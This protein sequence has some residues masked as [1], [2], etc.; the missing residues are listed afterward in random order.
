MLLG[1]RSPLRLGLPL[2]PPHQEAEG[3]GQ[4]R[5]HGA[6]HALRHL[7]QHG[8]HRH[9][10]GQLHGRGPRAHQDHHGPGDKGP[11][12]RLLNT[13]S[14]LLFNS[15][16]S[17]L[18]SCAFYLL[19]SMK[20]CCRR[21]ISESAYLKWVNTR[22]AYGFNSVFN[23]KALVGARRRVLLR[24]CTTSPIN[25]LQHYYEV[26]RSLI[27]GNEFYLGFMYRTH[28]AEYF[29]IYFQSKAFT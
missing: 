29:F 4:E 3:G 8:R 22:L 10:R 13:G 21:S 9:L 16:W 25:R 19:A 2:P 7:H 15:V 5:R 28:L 17:V 27:R 26:H 14:L 20:Y 12:N 24:D 6:Q 1:V 11:H 18:Y 23:V